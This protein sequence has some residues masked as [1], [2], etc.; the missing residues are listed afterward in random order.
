M[1]LKTVIY[2]LGAGLLLKMII[3][4]IEGG[5]LVLALQ[6][7]LLL[8]YLIYAFVKAVEDGGGKDEHEDGGLAA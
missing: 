7:I 6:L 5:Y 1:R 4:L 8:L 2:G 3:E